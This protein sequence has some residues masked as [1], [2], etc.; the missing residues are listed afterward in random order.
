VEARIK[1]PSLIS[2]GDKKWNWGI[3][4]WR[5]MPIEFALGGL[6]DQ[7]M[8]DCGLEGNKLIYFNLGAAP[9]E[10]IILFYCRTRKIFP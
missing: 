10:Y 2:A 1:I 6:I 7:E 9:V 5:E 8:R 4:F 3:S